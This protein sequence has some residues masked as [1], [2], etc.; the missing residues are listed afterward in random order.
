MINRFNGL[1]KYPHTEA[2]E[3]FNKLMEER[4][5]ADTSAVGETAL[6]LVNFNRAVINIDLARQAM[7]IVQAETPDVSDASHFTTTS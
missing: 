2:D 5:M 3:D 6:R 4:Q 7:Q 1:H